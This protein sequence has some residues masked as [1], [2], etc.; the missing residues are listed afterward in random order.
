MKNL[1]NFKFVLYS[2]FILFNNLYLFAQNKLY[3]QTVKIEC[4]DQDLD[5]AI[6]EPVLNIEVFQSNKLIQTINYTYN[7]TF[8]L[9]KHFDFTDIN[10]DGYNDI[11][12][13]AGLTA[14]R[15]QL[16]YEV[17]LWY[18]KKNQ[19]I[20]TSEISDS[21]PN[22]YIDAEKKL[23]YSFYMMNDGRNEYHIFKFEDDHFIEKDC[24]QEF[25][26]IFDYPV[27]LYE[28]ENFGKNCNF[29][30]VQDLSDVW[31]RVIALS[32]FS[33]DYSTLEKRLK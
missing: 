31:K 1:N 4:S 7:D 25:V 6:I 15:G 32:N 24:L 18:P 26:Y 10:F 5:K 30:T 21:M 9:I 23:L 29:K 3:K 33:Y 11:V 19:F 13:L 8:M 2:F 17:Y 28:N 27:Y 20:H 22:L 12:I 14:N 16:Y